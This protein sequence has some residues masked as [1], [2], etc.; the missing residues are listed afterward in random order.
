MI[1]YILKKQVRII[2]SISLNFIREIYMQKLISTNRLVGLVGQRGVGKTTLL[3]QYLKTNYKPTEYLYFS[4]D[5][6][7]IIDSSIYDIADEFVKLG[8]K[9]IVIDEIH[10]YNNWA[11][12][13]K[14]IYDSF[15][16]LIIRFS[17]SSM[18]N[19]LDQK[20]DLSRR[21][22]ISYVKPL[23]FREF[24]KL[25][26]NINLPQFKLDEI[27]EKYND[28]SSSLALEHP[29]LYKNFLKYLQIGYYP[30]FMEDEIEYKNKLF[31][32]C[33]KIINEDIPSLKKIDFTHLSLFKK[34]IAKLIYSKVPYKVNVSALSK[35][36]GISHPTLLTYLDILD[37]TKIIR[38]IKKYSKKVSQK[39][40]KLLFSNTNL[41]YSYADEFGVEVDIGTVR[42]TFFASC[43]ENIYYSDIGDFRVDD[44]IFEIG[45]KNKSFKQINGIEK[46]FLVID[47]DY[48]M[49]RGKIP[50]WL[51]GL[52]S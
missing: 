29:T 45:G 26:Q 43:F 39:P 44:Y 41:L 7:Y 35:E 28:I 51:F 46:S 47:T 34:F 13:L 18:L 21:A 42:E 15:P 52:I 14:S 5:D 4:A 10:K 17:G 30:F 22:V 48:S 27:L 6:V 3:L 23:S 9:V 31:N 49:E 50:L 37:K 19:I 1:K 38:A 8:G 20:Y 40:D 11:I 25:S 24:L 36:F 16:D 12:E 32:A 2:N 33:D